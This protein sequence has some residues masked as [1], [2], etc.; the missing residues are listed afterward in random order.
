MKHE[1]D[2]TCIR[3]GCGGSCFGCTLGSCKNCGASEGGLATECPNVIISGQDMDEI[4]SGTKDFIG[5]KW[6]KK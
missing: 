1:M 2:Y 4:Y 3:Q 5:G 6:V